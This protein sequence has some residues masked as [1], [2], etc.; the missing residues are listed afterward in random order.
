M[1][2]K[3]LNVVLDLDQTLIYSETQELK[4]Q[5]DF[6]FS[7]DKE[8]FFV[9]KRPGLDEFI[10]NLFK[11][12]KSVSIWTAATRS[13][14]NKIVKNVFTPAQKKKLKFIWTR[15]QT[16]TLNGHSYLKNMTKV[17]NKYKTMNSNNTILLDDNP[18]HFIASPKSLHYIKPW[19]PQKPRDK[20]LSKITKLIKLF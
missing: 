9:Y 15:P 11:Q 8:K 18:D 3:K 10:D 16:S 1:T 17:F 13:Y 4:K 2:I 5:P 14:C 7:L 19:T 20:E 12:C 6:I